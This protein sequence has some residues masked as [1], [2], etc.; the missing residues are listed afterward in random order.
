MIPSLK[1]AENTADSVHRGRDALFGRL[2]GAH[3]PRHSSFLIMWDLPHCFVIPCR[4]TPLGVWALR[5]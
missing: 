5:T 1:S 3:W 4:R 2:R